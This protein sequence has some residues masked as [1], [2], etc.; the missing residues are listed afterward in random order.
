ML[1]IL[2]C[3]FIK[4]ILLINVRAWYHC[5]SKIREW[6]FFFDKLIPESSKLI[7]VF[8]AEN[9]KAVFGSTRMNSL[10]LIRKIPEAHKRN[11]RCVLA[12]EPRCH[13]SDC[14]HELRNR[15]LLVYHTDKLMSC[16]NI[17]KHTYMSANRRIGASLPPL[18]FIGATKIFAPVSGI[19]F[20]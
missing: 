14:V 11:I 4:L 3:G 1:Q 19:S 13:M 20:A 8:R 7:T 10:I 6:Y 16:W 18:I 12:Y 15:Y 9:D 5:L 17:F 2:L